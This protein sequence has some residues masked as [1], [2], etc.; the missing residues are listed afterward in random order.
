[1]HS[2]W[3]T[4][5]LFTIVTTVL[6]GLGYPL[7]VTGIAA[8]IF[9][10][11]AAG[12]LIKLKDGTVVGSELIGQSFTDAK[13]NPPRIENGMTLRFRNPSKQEQ[14]SLDA[15]T[16]ALGDE[17]AVLTIEQNRLVASVTLVEAIGGG[18][19]STQLPTIAKTER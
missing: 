12:S 7:F 14:Q 13:G 2:V 6:L 10:H 18:W 3:K 15:Q 11:Q 17:Q 9:P 5:I 16:T 1:M 4:S 8:V 19:D